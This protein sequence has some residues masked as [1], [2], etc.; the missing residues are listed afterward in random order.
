MKT[1]DPSKYREISKPFVDG[2]EANQA[3]TQFVNDVQ[4]AREKHRIPDVVILCEISHLLDEVEVRGHSSASFGDSSKTLT[5][6][7]RAYGSEQTKHEQMLQ[8]ITSLAR[9]A[10]RSRK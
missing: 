3:I 9:K 2:N 10:E 1:D 5:M 6:I 4:A 7:A 8:V